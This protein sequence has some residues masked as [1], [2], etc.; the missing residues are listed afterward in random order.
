MSKMARVFVATDLTTHSDEAIR[1]GDERARAAQ[2]E[3]AVC[4][5]LPNLAR[6]NP[7]FP[8]LSPAGLPDLGPWHEQAFDALVAQVARLTGRLESEFDALIDDGIAHAQI[9]EQAEQWKADVVVVGGSGPSGLF[10]GV[11]RKVVRYAHCAVLVA[12]ARPAR[13]RVMA[14]TDFSDAAA[15]AVAA[16]GELARASGARV[17]ALHAVDVSIPAFTA[18]SASFG[19]PYVGISPEVHGDVLAAAQAMLEDVLRRL[20]IEGDTHVVVGA[21]ASAVVGAVAELQPELLVVGTAG[22]TGLRRVIMGSVAEAVVERAACPVLVVR[23]GH[24]D[25]K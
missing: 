14:A 18:I 17:V 19:S 5:V 1:Q 9:L 3:L 8:H 25:A 13:G 21:A 10:G 12:R 20:E 22:R 16:A 15:P 23:L 11:A 4:H 24:G 7:L 2:G 6:I